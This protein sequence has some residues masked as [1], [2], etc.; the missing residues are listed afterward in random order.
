[1]CFVMDKAFLDPSSPLL[2]SEPS[3]VRISDLDLTCP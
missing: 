3:S 1:M 2:F